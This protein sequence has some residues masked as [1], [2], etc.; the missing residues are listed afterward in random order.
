MEMTEFEIVKD[1]SES[2]DK[3]AQIGILADLNMCSPADIVGVLQKNGI[4]LPE[5]VTSKQYKEFRRPAAGRVEWNEENIERLRGYVLDGLTL[6]EIAERFGTGT[7]A[8]SKQIA[9]Y[10]LRGKKSKKA[11]ESID[12]TYIKQLEE[13][14]KDAK[15]E[16]QRILAE[17]NKAVADYTEIVVGLEGELEKEKERNEQLCAE[18][19][20]L[21]ENDM[22]SEVAVQAQNIKGLAVLGLCAV[23]KDCAIEGVR[24]A[25]LNIAESADVIVEEVDKKKAPDV[26]APEASG[27]SR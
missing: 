20:L 24:A 27:L 12:D 3:A 14:L 1:Y 8:V 25:F 4:P 10:D 18:I 6:D 13:Q 17:H 26:G 2:A 7:T 21:L 19:H 9:K 16:K 11:K 5:G 15:G 23:G 22:Y